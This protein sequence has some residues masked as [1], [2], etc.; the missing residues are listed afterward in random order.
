MLKMKEFLAFVVSILLV[1]YIE[2]GC[3]GCP[4]EVLAKDG[5]WP[6]DVKDAASFAVH[7]LGSDYELDKILEAKTQVAFDLKTSNMILKAC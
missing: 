2:G 5:E 7:E 4:E 3:P 1:V 6:Q